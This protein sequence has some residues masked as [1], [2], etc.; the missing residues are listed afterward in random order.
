MQHWWQR[1]QLDILGEKCSNDC[2][3]CKWHE[4]N[5]WLLTRFA[6]LIIITDIWNIPLNQYDIDSFLCMQW[7]WRW[8]PLNM[9]QI[10]KYL[11]MLERIRLAMLWCTVTWTCSSS[12]PKISH[13]VIHHY[14]SVHSKIHTMVSRCKQDC[15]LP[16]L[17]VMTSCDLAWVFQEITCQIQELH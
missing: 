12:E 17:Q 8:F 15:C 2:Y 4:S 13:F 14:Y 1:E 9:L 3:A 6:L 10:D 7:Q 16:D 11:C 5:C